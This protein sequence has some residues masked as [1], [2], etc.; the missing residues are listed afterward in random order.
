MAIQEETHVAQA[1]Q[2]QEQ[3]GGGRLR[4]HVRWPWV[5]AFCLMVC[6]IWG[7]SLE[8]ASA[9]GALSGSVLAM[10]QGGLAAIGLPYE[11]LTEHI[12]RK[13]AH[14]SEYMALGLIGMQ[15]FTP[16][17]ATRC[18]A[19][20]ALTAA[21]LVAI[22]SCDETIQL[23]VDGRSGQVS[24]VLLDCCGAATGVVL[25]L[26]GHALLRRRRAMKAP[27]PRA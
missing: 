25:T 1:Q 16:H 22:P 5:A 8:P 10:L 9:S 12:V 6:F 23:F 24:D 27:A 4:D 18:T 15:A 14:F 3:A 19:A 26:L 21:L 2:A 20:I 13:C 7:N 17:R 11:W